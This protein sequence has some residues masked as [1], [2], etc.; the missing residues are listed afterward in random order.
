MTDPDE[1]TND[2]DP[3]EAQE[4]LERLR[5]QTGRDWIFPDE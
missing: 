4:A 3:K 1:Q 5:E 2:P